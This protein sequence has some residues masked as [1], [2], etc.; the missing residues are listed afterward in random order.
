M[1]KAPGKAMKATKAYVRS[2]PKPPKARAGDVVK[3]E[4]FDEKNLAWFFGRD[5]SGA[6]GYFAVAWFRLDEAGGTATALRDY[7]A[8]ELSVE[9]GD[10]VEVTEEYGSWLLVKLR[11]RT[12]WIPEDCVE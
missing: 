3:F 7:D 8:N 11:E 5:A 6:E 12:G 10:S 9:A 4:R 1:K 2:F